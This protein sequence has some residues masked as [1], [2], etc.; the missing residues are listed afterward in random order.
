MRILKDLLGRVFRHSDGG[1]RRRVSKWELL[2]HTRQF[3]YEWQIQGL[4]DTENERVRKREIE[5]ELRTRTLQHKAEILYEWQ[6]KD[7]EGW[8]K[9]ERTQNGGGW[10][11]IYKGSTILANCQ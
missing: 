2:V 10:R 4:Q 7:L 11:S 5:T 6:G 1:S 8:C 9:G 3:S